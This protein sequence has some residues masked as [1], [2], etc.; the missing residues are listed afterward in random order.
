M[1]NITTTDRLTKNIASG[2]NTIY[3]LVGTRYVYSVG[4]SY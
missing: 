2:L 4:F 3:A 1:F